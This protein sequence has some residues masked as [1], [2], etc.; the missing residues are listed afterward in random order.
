MRR[1]LD[2]C[3]RALG[4]AVDSRGSVGYYEIGFD[5]GYEG[6][7]EYNFILLP[8]RLAQLKLGVGLPVGMLAS[9]HVR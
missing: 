7:G 6:V 1:S 4:S 8:V 5:V 2:V 3:V 9:R